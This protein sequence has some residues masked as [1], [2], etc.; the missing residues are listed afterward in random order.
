MGSSH[1]VIVTGAA[2]GIGS[3]IVRSLLKQ[4]G[5]SVVATDIVEGPLADQKKVYGDR[6][7]VVT[8]DIVK[9]EVS[10]QCVKLAIAKFNRITGVVLAAGVFGPC[11]RLENSPMEKW[12]RGIDINVLSH[13]S[14][15]HYAIPE[16]RKT[17]GC[18]IAATSGAG[19]APLF[20]G[21]G[22]YG[23]S[24][25]AVAFMVKQLHLEEKDIT[26]IGISPG[27]CDTKMVASLR[28]GQQDGWTAEDTKYYEDF[29]SKV[30]MVTPEVIGSIYAQVL[31]HANSELSGLVIDYD[32]PQLPV[33]E[34]LKRKDRADGPRS[35]AQYSSQADL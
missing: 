1:V 12:K 9:P 35:Y 15:L 18:V 31:T 26:A 14:T 20:A 6:L 10:E 25:A 2:G 23:M 32:D 17:K 5:A 7:E 4:H 19:V 21:W 34:H 3:E 24:K 16:L 33:E 29:V 28:S 8:G 27:L 30:D 22:F 11:H 13:L